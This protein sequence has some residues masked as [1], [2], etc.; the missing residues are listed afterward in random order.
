M[1]G[2]QEERKEPNLHELQSF[3]EKHCKLHELRRTSFGSG[4]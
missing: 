4:E 3:Q 1:Y 2:E